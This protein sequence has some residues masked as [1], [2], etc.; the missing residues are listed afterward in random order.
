MEIASVFPDVEMPPKTAITFHRDACPECAG[1]A[2]DLE[3]YR[4]Q[5]IGIQVIRIIHQELVHLS[6]SGWRWILPYYL[7]YC[8]TPEAEYSQME[9][10]FLIY[11]LGPAL[12]FQKVTIERLSCLNEKQI[13]SLIHFLGWC[14]DQDFWR[15][16]C[17]N[18]IQRA[19]NFLA[20]INKPGSTS[21]GRV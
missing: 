5:I 20:T 21:R 4:G 13:V 3:E 16:Y 9:T 14:N 11:A 6:A 8:L 15:E 1:L 19:I 17:Q 18:D 7:G 2:V 10:E 12:E